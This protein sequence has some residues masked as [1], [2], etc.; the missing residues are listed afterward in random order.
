MHDDDRRFIEASFFE[1]Y[2]KTLRLRDLPFE[3]YKYGMNHRIE[4]LLSE[5][6]CIVACAKVAPDE[7]LGYCI[8]Q[9]NYSP[10]HV[11]YIYVKSMYRRQ[12]IGKSLVE[13][14]VRLFTHD[15]AP[16][17]THTP[18]PDGRKFFD[19]LEMT[20]EPAL[21]EPKDLRK[22]EKEPA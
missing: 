17:Y 15:G 18:T 20:F 5:S 22:Q 21:A 12:G 13:A 1:S 4:R 2:L 9:E 19:A 14:S 3:V 7:V 8:Y 16:C 10:P 6:R 11:H